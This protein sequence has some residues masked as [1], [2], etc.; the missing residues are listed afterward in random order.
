ML[1]IKQF[2]DVK[3][4]GVKFG[5]KQYRQKFKRDCNTDKAEYLDTN[6]V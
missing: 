2:E 4:M 3:N 5:N 1:L 6:F